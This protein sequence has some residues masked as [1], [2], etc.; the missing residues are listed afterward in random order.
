ME[1][2]RARSL[3]DHAEDARRRSRHRLRTVWIPTTLYASLLAPTLALADGASTGK[4]L[5]LAASPV[6]A[7]LALLW[8]EAEGG[9]HGL[10]PRPRR[11][12]VLPFGILTLA[13]GAGALAW[14]LGVGVVAAYGTPL[15]LAAS[16]IVVAWRERDGAMAVVVVGAMGLASIILV[17]LRGE[18][19]AALVALGFAVT[20]LV[21]RIMAVS[22]ARQ[23]R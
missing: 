4:L 12:F 6:V 15:L 14:S 17:Q 11:F 20:L 7:V 3:I 18:I 2:S 1:A 16:Y 19:A 21:I 9:R 22:T 8:I 10:V 13:L 5:W 23:T